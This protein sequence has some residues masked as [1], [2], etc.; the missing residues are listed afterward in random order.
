MNRLKLS[1]I[2]HR[3]MHKSCIMTYN[4]HCSVFQIKNQYSKLRDIIRLVEIQDALDS[5]IQL[6]PKD[7]VDYFYSVGIEYE[8][9]E[10]YYNIVCNL[11]EQLKKCLN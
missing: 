3:K 4:D 8:S 6:R 1:N 11:E 5:T 2:K 7:K 10:K 9:V